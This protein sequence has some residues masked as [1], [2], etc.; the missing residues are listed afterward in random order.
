MHQL[1]DEILA[2]MS[3]PMSDL[4]EDVLGQFSLGALT[5]EPRGIVIEIDRPT[6]RGRITDVVAP[7]EDQPSSNVHGDS[8]RLR[9]APGSPSALATDRQSGRVS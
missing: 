1:T 9:R 4:L 7:L 8:T 5:G 3:M 2:R 6:A